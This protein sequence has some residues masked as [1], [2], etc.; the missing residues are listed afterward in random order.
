VDS[1][2]TDLGSLFRAIDKHGLVEPHKTHFIQMIK[3]LTLKSSTED[4]ELV[5]NYAQKNMEAICKNFDSQNS[6][7]VE[8]FIEILSN[9]IHYYKVEDLSKRLLQ[10]VLLKLDRH[11]SMVVG[12]NMLLLKRGII[13]H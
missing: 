4:K 1:E 2:H 8:I 6:T 3:S 13:P 12:L 9:I 11:F 10:E 7:K 5:W